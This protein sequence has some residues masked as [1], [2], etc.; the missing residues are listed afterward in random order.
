M[1]IAMVAILAFA[2]APIFA[3]G[4]KASTA[5]AEKASSKGYSC[6]SSKGTG[7]SASLVSSDSKA[8]FCYS[9]AA[10]ECAE[11]MGMTEEECIALCK[12]GKLTM[13]NMSIDGMTCGGCEN[14]L[15]ASLMK[16]PGV[17][18]VHSISHKTGT[19]SVYLD[20]REG[21]SDAVVT[22]VTNKGYTAEIIPAVA[23]AE[24]TTGTKTANSKAGCSTSKSAC[25]SKKAGTTATT[26]KAEGT[27]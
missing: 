10:K 26:V 11:A 5:N 18:Y 20:T 3:C 2:A 17:V 6:S 8:N 19:A 24:T 25:S 14:S 27:K 4:E 13:V 23:T 1:G 16:V 22:A 15:T 21:K 7:T 9:T 12:S